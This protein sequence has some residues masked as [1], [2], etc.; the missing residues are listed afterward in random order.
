LFLT[1][2][3][4]F[5]DTAQGSRRLMR[6]ILACTLSLLYLAVLA[7]ARPYQDRFDDALAVLS[8]MILAGCFA[9]G[10]ALKLCEENRWNDS[11]MD[12]LGVASS[13]QASLFV[14][15]MVV[16]MVTAALLV[17]S[18]QVISAA[19]GPPTIRLV[20]TRRLPYLDLPR[21]CAYHFFVSHVWSTGQVGAYYPRPF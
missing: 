5:I 10:I 11:C 13:F 8:N 1:A 6:L 18:M 16:G 17:V 14:A 19:V 9:S 21:G 3:V 7:L 20:A 12:F 4:L 2:I 15:I